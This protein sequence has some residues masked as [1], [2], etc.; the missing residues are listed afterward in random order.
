MPK[1]FK[2][3]TNKLGVPKKMVFVDKKGE[4]HL[5]PTLTEKK[6]LATHYGQTAIITDYNPKNGNLIKVSKGEYTDF[7][8]KKKKQEKA[9]KD[10][11]KATVAV[12]TAAKK[13]R[14][15][16]KGSKNKKT[17]DKTVKD[18]EVKMDA[19]SMSKDIVDNLISAA[20]ASVPKARG[21]P[22]G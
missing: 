7:K 19:V 9:A 1:Y 3:A 20:V 11:V 13:M 5:L 21:R 2:A 12:E 22:K 18:L 17:Q 16:P 15:R 6:H 8:E 14:G 4:T 10:L